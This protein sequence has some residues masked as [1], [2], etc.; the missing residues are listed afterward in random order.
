[1]K[2]LFFKKET[3]K[4]LIAM[5]LAVAIVFSLGACKNSSGNKGDSGDKTDNSSS[6][7]STDSNDKTEVA[8]PIDD[9]ADVPASKNTYPAPTMVE[10]AQLL[11]EFP[12]PPAVIATSKF[13][14]KVS[15]EFTGKVSAGAPEIGNTTDQAGPNDSISIYGTGF[16]GGKVYAYGLVKGVG[17]TKQLAVTS[18][19][20]DFVNA[21]I[22]PSFDYGM[23]IVWIEG[24]D[25]KI[26][27]PVRINA[28]TITWTSSTKVSS[29]T[30]LKI[31]GKFLTSNNADGK[32]AKSYV[33][34]TDGKLAY[35]VT[36]TEATP[37]RVTVKLPKGLKEGGKYKIWLHN[38]HG[39]AYGW[40]NSL[41]IKYDSAAENFWN[42]EDSSIHTVTVTN[43]RS[44]DE[45]ILKA[46]KDAKVGDTVYLPA[47]VYE[48]NDQIKLNKSVKLQGEGKD[49]VIFVCVFAKNKSGNSSLAYGDLHAN[50]SCTAAIDVTATPCEISG[51]T[52]TEYIEGGEYSQGIKKPS[53]YSID[54]AYGTFIRGYECG[55][56]GVGGS[57]K[58]DNCNFKVQRLYCD[59]TNCIYLSTQAQE[60]Y[61]E[62]Y[63]VKYKNYTTSNQGSAPMWIETDRVE[64]SNCFFQVAKGMMIRRMNN[65]SIHDNT[66]EG[67]WIIAGNSGPCAIA[68]NNSQNLD[69]SNNRIYGKDE[70]TDP[71]G[72]VVTGDQTFARTIVFQM[73]YE[74]GKNLYIMNNNASRVGELNYNA[75]EHILF[76]EVSITYVGKVDI[77][78][79]QKTITLK[80]MP[81]EKWVGK[82]DFT[83]YF[84]NDDGT[85]KLGHTRNVIGQVVT[86]TKGK[87]A[88]QWRNIVDASK[89]SVVKIDK[90]FDVQPDANSTIV[91]SPA[92][93]ASVVYANK[94]EGPKIYYK[95]YNSTNGVNAYATMVDTI[96]DRNNFSQMQA[97]LAINPQYNMKTY[98]YKGNKVTVDF[99]FIMYCDLLAMNNTINDT[100]YGIWNF[101]SLTLD[102][103]DKTD[104]EPTINL[105]MGTIFRNNT[106]SNQRYL[107]GGA[108]TNDRTK[109]QPDFLKRGGVSIV[110]GRD[111]YLASQS[112][113]TR[114]WMNDTVVEN[115]KLNN[116]AHNY[117]DISFSQTGTII[118]NNSYDGK[119]GLAFDSV[120]IKHQAHNS[121]KT[122]Q[123]P[124]YFK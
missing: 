78:K 115:N 73:P 89:G 108:D 77:A 91:V 53:N 84:T 9:K 85:I 109:Q 90:P 32:D 65:S 33:F 99:N 75:G 12:N 6:Q 123:N 83:G 19:R 55:D 82:G 103:I 46:V 96:I 93:V 68:D 71:N 113:S 120:N 18:Q 21:V 110:V 124:I 92:F 57:F 61:H 98:I 56:N 69:I 51:I 104:G 59:A 11:K 111:Y 24:K 106:I 8:T 60:A 16:A 28:P 39:G 105:Q 95:N 107:T 42:T 62:E 27:A 41:D 26:S 114:Y 76:E 14:D 74:V 43:G 80:E 40:S 17:Q 37:Y 3:V 97:G 101:P 25:G 117:L 79:D 72:Y 88:G 20:D 122:P 29:E 102:G 10:N 35:K 1:M 100:R 63:K 4:S 2:N 70:K 23:Y 36:V 50:G 30:E 38:G 58:I 52:F 81:A 119:T 116:P 87:G 64:V 118:R 15:V 66:F 54:Y 86:I 67:I 7:G 22:D 13:S 112:L 44:S 45:E 48:I 31:Y 34:I 94:I 121:G 5:L 49:K 47:G